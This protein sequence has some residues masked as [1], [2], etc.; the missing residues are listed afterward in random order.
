[1]PGRCR[2]LMEPSHGLTKET[3]AIGRVGLSGVC[4]NPS[5]LE[6]SPMGVCRAGRSLD[7]SA[8][9]DESLRVS[10]TKRVCRACSSHVLLPR[11]GPVALSAWCCLS[12]REARTA[13]IEV[14]RVSAVV[15]Q[16]L[17]ANGLCSR[18]HS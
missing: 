18:A 3:R 2:A 10:R 12:A 16:R 9:R 5:P 8:F 13:P 11:P 17:V 14:W 1:M 6:A 4:D 7:Q 15:S